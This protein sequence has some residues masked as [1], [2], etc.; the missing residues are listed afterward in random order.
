M[1]SHHLVLYPSFSSESWVVAAC[2]GP[3]HYLVV[4]DGTGT[5]RHRRYL[6]EG[7]GCLHIAWHFGGSPPGHD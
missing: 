6:A 5:S 3:C 1:S 4:L 2:T 7:K